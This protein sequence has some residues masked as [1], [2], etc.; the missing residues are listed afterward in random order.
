M[1]SYSRGT[2]KVECTTPTGKEFESIY[3]VEHEHRLLFLPMASTN[4][5]WINEAVSESLMRMFND[6]DFLEF[7]ESAD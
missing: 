1:G 4:S 2:F 7:L 3:R 6:N 5:K